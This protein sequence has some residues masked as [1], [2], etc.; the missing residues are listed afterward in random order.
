[1]GGPATP[2]AHHL[3]R[4]TLLALCFLASFVAGCAGSHH[5]VAYDGNA[6]VVDGQRTALAATQF[7]YWRLPSPALWLSSLERIRAE[8]YNAVALDFYWGYHSAHRGAFDFTGVRDVDPLLEA[9]AKAHVYVIARPGPFIDGGAEA[10]G[11]PDWMLARSGRPETMA[12]RY[13]RESRRWLQ[14]IDAIIAR[15]QLTDGSGTVVLYQISDRNTP[16]LS[17]ARQREA[18]ADG[19]A[20]PFAGGAL[21]SAEDGTH[22]GWTGDPLHAYGPRNSGTLEPAPLAEAA[23]S[24]PAIGRWRRQDDD[25]ESRRVFD[26][27]AWPPLIAGLAIDPDEPTTGARY[28][29]VPRSPRL[30]FASVNDYG[31][32]HG[33]VWYR[34][35]FRANGTERALRLRGSA[36]RRGACSIWLNGRFLASA[37]ADDA[38]EISVTVTFGAA[39]LRRGADNVFSVLFEN[40]GHNEDFDRDVNRAQ[41]RGMLGAVLAGSTQPIQ[42]HVLGNGVY[43]TD[44]VRGP[45][46]AG[47]LAGEIAGWQ[48]PAFPDAAWPATTLPAHAGRPGVTWY[49]ARA[50]VKP[51]ADAATSDA[52][53]IRDAEPGSY[54]AFVYV[55]GWL[56]GQYVSEGGSQSVFPIPS[57]VLSHDGDATIAIAAWSLDGRGGLGTVSFET[58]RAPDDPH[59]ALPDIPEVRSKDGV[60]RL[61]LDVASGNSGDRPHF[62]FHGQDATPT[63][64]VRPGDTIAIALHN[65]LHPSNDT[66]N[67]VNLHFH[68]LDV[69]PTPPGDE[70]LETL[71]R[72][73]QTLHYRVHVPANQPPG[74][75]WYHSHSHGET[76]WQVTSGMGGAIVVEGLQD[77]VPDLATMRERTIF[78]RNVQDAPG[79]MQIPW[80]ARPQTRGRGS[81]DSDEAL[82]A[83]EPCA[84]EFGTHV[85]VNGAFQPLISI[86]PGEK[87]FFRLVNASASRVLDLAI[88]DEPIG[89]VAV[90]GY[91]VGDSPG[92]A[93]ILWTDHILIP[94]AG[95]AEFIATGPSR[96]AMLRSR[97]YDSG[98]AGDRDPETVLAI[99]Q[100]SASAR[101]V[102]T[103]SPS[104][105]ARP[106]DSATISRAAPVRKRIIRLSE[107]A[108]GFYINGKAFRMSGMPSMSGMNAA[109]SLV[110]RA[111]TLEEWTVLNET[112]EVHDFHIHQVHFQVESLDGAPLLPQVWRDTVL[113]P[114]QTRA[115]GRRSPG[116]AKIL[117]DFRNPGIR[118]TFVFHCHMLDHE[119]GGMMATIKVI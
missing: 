76:Y 33:A 3:G 77:L 13:A 81:V 55:N 62:V 39:A 113:V 2:A 59:V 26:D 71:A 115:A 35:H 85:T 98:P 64:R 114:A 8:G 97:C 106:A 28:K 46:N 25:A 95:R 105:T 61:S 15:H 47:G 78:V 111:G 58:V 100:P 75:Y 63:L 53:R 4:A 27:Q 38:G 1:M 112:D 41:P 67:A 73:G 65:G 43:N 60:A 7:H 11:V 34:G 88:D 116:V 10:G 19:V 36:G 32:D 74:T 99:L 54:R 24:L 91:P 14:Q 52:V 107:D 83:N 31:F 92:N 57:G 87:Q 96:P 104:A 20:V 29:H 42:W 102:E 93:T 109:P 86:A 30:D 117:V 68:G 101:Q 90:D 51:P 66:A 21:P 16:G 40:M 70:V 45:L 79:I 89:L 118:G 48:Q 110:A 84:A 108:R 37:S 44:P 103:P 17:A 56:V 69:A 6:L 72:P 5:T 80:Y 94:P 50:T 12:A 23:A 49:R 9:A 119:D 18:R 82:G 22:W